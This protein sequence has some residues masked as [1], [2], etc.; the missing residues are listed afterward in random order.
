MEIKIEKLVNLFVPLYLIPSAYASVLALAA[1][2]N[3]MNNEFHL[4]NETEYEKLCVYN[5]NNNIQFPHMF[6]N[7]CTKRSMHRTYKHTPH[8]I[9]IIDAEN[10]LLFSLFLFMCSEFPS[11][12]VHILP[13]QTRWISFFDAKKKLT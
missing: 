3:Q 6:G 4:E 11:K 1:K 8:M 13:F 7:R 10:V 2:Q 5:W 12:L 9:L